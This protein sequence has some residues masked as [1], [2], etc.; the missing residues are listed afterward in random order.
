M[1]IVLFLVGI[2]LQVNAQ[3]IVTKPFLTP[4]KMDEIMY[5]AFNAP[6]IVRERE[7]KKQKEEALRKMETEKEEKERNNA[8]NNLLNQMKN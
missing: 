8:K 1:K 7:E 4:E 3:Q 6:K 5:N 2:S